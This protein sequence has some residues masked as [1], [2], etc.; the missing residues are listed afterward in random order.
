MKT[1]A[2]QYYMHDGSTAFRFELAGNLNHEGARRLDQD[3]R[4]ASSVIGD[5]TLIVDM[6]FVTG[7]DEQGRALIT[8]WHREGARLITNTKASRAL[9]ESILGEPL[10]EPPANVRF[11]ATSDRTWIPFRSSF[12]ASAVNLVLLLAPFVFP[13]KTNGATLKSETVDAWDDYLQTASA[14]LQ[15][16][17]RR[18]GSFL[19]TFENAARAAEVRG[20]KIIVVPAPVQ[21]PK[22]VP[23][24]L[25]HH[26]MGAMFLPNL[27]LDNIL[28]V[29]R[30]YDHYLEF[31]RPTV[32]ASRVTARGDSDDVRAAHQRQAS[33]PWRPLGRCPNEVVTDKDVGDREQA[34]TGGDK[35]A[36]VDDREPQPHGPPRRHRPNW[37]SRSSLPPLAAGA[38]RIA[39]GSQGK[40]RN[41]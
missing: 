2:L 25:I 24:G 29:T 41:L 39:A 36:R 22:K 21:I 14:N 3:W 34:C 20:G 32:I 15:A 11:G 28:E 33:L 19:W 8:R 17:V 7:V 18:G 30:D 13:V 40:G 27:K 10:P 16:R 31:Y 26:W 4:T 1:Q 6:T 5:R 37:M 12:V 35:Q 9:A 38:T 23:G